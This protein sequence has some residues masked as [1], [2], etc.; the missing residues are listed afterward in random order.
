LKQ[1]LLSHSQTPKFIPF[2]EIHGRVR[3]KENKEERK[4]SMNG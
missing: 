3:N 4:Q 1:P 2:L